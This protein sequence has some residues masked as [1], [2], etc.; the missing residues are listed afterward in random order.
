MPSFSLQ[1][2]RKQKMEG[3]RNPI[4]FFD[5]SIAN[6]PAGRIEMILRSD[7]V[8]RTCEN[9]RCL[10]TGEKSTPTKK[11]WFKHSTFHRVIP[12]FMIHG[13]DFIEGNG[14]G[15][16]S[17]F[18]PTF[19]DENFILKHSGPGLLSMANS[20]VNSNSSQFFITCAETPWL[21]GSHVVF[22]AVSN[23]M[24]VVRQIEKVGSETG[25]T[26]RQVLITNCGEI[27][28]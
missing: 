21:D 1:P 8:P 16:E 28:I 25:R 18:G 14:I 13:G 23:G 3:Q 7:V 9:F 27:Q 15:G 19:T 26:S 2:P 5:I 12:S 11:L 10:C 6:R 4:V 22:G 20:G 17:I 24:E